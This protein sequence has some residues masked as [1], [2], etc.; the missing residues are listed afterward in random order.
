MKIMKEDFIVCRINILI[1]IFL[2]VLFLLPFSLTAQF[3]EDMDEELE[4]MEEA[5]GEC[6]PDDLTT[7][8]DSLANIEYSDDEIKKWISLGHEHYKHGDYKAAVPYLWK[9]FMLDSGKYGKYAVR[10]LAESYFGLGVADTTLIVCYK[11]LDKFPD[12]PTLHY[13]AGTVQEKAGRIKCAIPHFEE[14]VK[15][16]PENKQYLEMYAFLLVKDEDERAIEIQQKV[17]N[18]YPDDNDAR[19]KLSR[20]ISIFGG[21][22]WKQLIEAWKNDPKN[23]NLAISAAEASI[24]A[25]EYKTALE[26]L[27]SV[28]N[29]KTEK[30]A[31]SY[32]L[33]AQCYE[34]L[35]Q[36]TNS[37]NDYKNL[38][39]I[40][41]DDVVTMCAI[42]DD[43]RNLNQFK[44]GVYWVQR[45]LRIKPG[46]GLAYIT[47]GDIYSS[48]VT[49][50]QNRGNR[51]RNYDDALVYKLAYDEY[52]KAR[53]D[54]NYR[55]TAIKRM[56]SL[57][58]FI[59][60]EEEKFM[61]QNRDYLKDSCYTSWINEKVKL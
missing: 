49:Y 30:K 21:D 52:N 22:A 45:A 10:E 2:A 60:T 33:R 11:G 48:A 51:T 18:L 20:Y 24:D 26:P 44:N 50:C 4:M 53:R 32:K 27:N 54:F 42:A 13:Y 25:G 55:S 37:I 16:H 40:N 57:L 8:Y 29:S 39:K 28:V 36:Y 3:D 5:E 17:V 12:N 59:P 14:L 47:M 34:S 9:V 7:V 23:V 58:S 38:L 1:I 31:T 35:D 15:S 19:I 41:P 56:K 43:Y 6:I 46:S 61:N